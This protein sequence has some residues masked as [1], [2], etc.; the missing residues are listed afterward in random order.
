MGLYFV[1]PSFLLSMLIHQSYGLYHRIAFGIMGR[2]Y[3]EDSMMQISTFIVFTFY[4]VKLTRSLRAKEETTYSMTGKI[5]NYFNKKIYYIKYNYI[6]KPVDYHKKISVVLIGL[7]PNL[8]YLSGLFA[9]IGSLNRI[10]LMNSVLLVFTLYMLFESKDKKNSMTFYMI[11]LVFQMCIRYISFII[12]N[13]LPT[14][15]I[16]LLSIIGVYSGNK[17]EYLFTMVCFWVALLIASM[18]FFD[19]SYSNRKTYKRTGGF[20]ANPLEDK[21]S[22]F[23]Q[24][25]DKIKVLAQHYF[26]WIF[27]WATLNL[28][29]IDD[30][31]VVVT[32]LFYIESI[33]MVVH[34]ILWH[35]NPQSMFKIIY[36]TFL[37][38][39]TFIWVVFGVRLLMMFF[40]YATF[41]NPIQSIVT[42]LYPDT[43]KLIMGELF[44]SRQ[45]IFLFAEF[46]QETLLLTIAMISKKVIYK[47][48]ETCYSL[49]D[50]HNFTNSHKKLDHK[51]FYLIYN[52][53]TKEKGKKWNMTFVCVFLIAD[54]ITT[55][56]IIYLLLHNLSFFI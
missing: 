24:F 50:S 12:P 27:H 11:Y 17:D 1:M 22:S 15:N 31:D 49:D 28:V 53:V 44:Q 25:V 45:V 51:D 34:Y 32:I 16:E 21:K 42:T 48:S 37:V 23:V 43:S 41:F 38:S 56:I 52:P 40:R 3:I 19:L 10:S 30:K 4:I 55:L 5:V 8:I 36:R 39:Y 9:I 47:Y 26:I 29:I 46:W 14:L 7:K 35:K 18:D 13:W 20:I 6:N 54:M 33:L 2:K